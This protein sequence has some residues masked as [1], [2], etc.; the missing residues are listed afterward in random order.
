MLR[1]EKERNARNLHWH[2]LL[3][4]AYPKV[5]IAVWLA[6]DVDW[7]VKSCGIIFDN[8]FFSNRSNSFIRI[9]ELMM[10]HGL[11]VC[12]CNS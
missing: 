4:K 1:G 10:K 7:N 9:M 3:V 2:Y 11:N 8:I 6:Q 12:S 5:V